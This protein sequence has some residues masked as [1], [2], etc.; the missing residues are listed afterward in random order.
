[1]TNKG[2]SAMKRIARQE[3]ARRDEVAYLREVR[4]RALDTEALVERDGLPEHFAR[5]K[6][7][8][9]ERHPEWFA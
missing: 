4:Q 3:A 1:M 9:R 2:T 7:E 6:A 5:M 8:T